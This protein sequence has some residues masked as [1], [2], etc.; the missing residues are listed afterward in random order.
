[1]AVHAKNA[2]RCPSISKVFNLSL[3]V[4]TFETVGAKGLVSG[5]NGKIF[6]LVEA[7]AAAVGAVV[8]YEGTIAK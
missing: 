7:A 3:A 1:M 8:A 4:A 5:Q 6:D 2:L